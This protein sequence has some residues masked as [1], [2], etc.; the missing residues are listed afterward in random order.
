MKGL[1]VNKRKISDYSHFKIKVFV[2]TLA[3]AM[4]IGHGLRMIYQGTFYPNSFYSPNLFDIFFD[5]VTLTIFG[6]ILFCYGLFI[7]YSKYSSK[8]ISL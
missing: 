4:M 6:I 2:F 5:W 7:F 1:I 8:N 3:G